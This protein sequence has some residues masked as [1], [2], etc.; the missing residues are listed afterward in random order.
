MIGL[1][2]MEKEGIEPFPPARH[3]EPVLQDFA[4][5]LLQRQ[6]ASVQ[7]TRARTR[8]VG[9]RLW[10]VFAVHVFEDLDGI[11]RGGEVHLRRGALCEQNKTSRPRLKQNITPTLN[12]SRKAS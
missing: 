9:A 11:C 8:E 12:S 3:P 1:R 10:H 2:S 5:G 4:P 7:K 6:T